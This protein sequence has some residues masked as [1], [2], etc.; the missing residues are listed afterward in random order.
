MSWRYQP[1]FKGDGDER[2][3]SLCECYFDKAG[4]LEGWTEKAAMGV[5]GNDPDDLR[6]SLCNML[7]DAMKWVPVRFEDLK[8]GMTFTRAIT[9]EDAD[10]IA[11]TIQTM[12]ELASSANRVN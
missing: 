3:Y 11:D 4:R 7:A 10:R 9:Q 6:G 8:V 1:V 2:W 12:G 5:M